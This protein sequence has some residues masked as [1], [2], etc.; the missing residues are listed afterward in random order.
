MLYILWLAQ[1]FAHPFEVGWYG[2]DMTMTLDSELVR[3]QYTQEVPVDFLLTEFKDFMAMAEGS[4]RQKAERF[5]A[6]LYDDLAA[7]L[8]LEIDGKP[9]AWM[10]AQPTH[11]TLRRQDQFF[12]LPLSLQAKLPQGVHQLLL[13]NQNRMENKGIY[14]SDIQS[15]DAIVV[16]KSN[17]LEVEA[18][19]IRKNHNLSWKKEEEFREVRLVYSSRHAA[20]AM[21]WRWWRKW[22]WGESNDTLRPEPSFAMQQQPPSL[23][24]PTPLMGLG[25]LVFSFMVGMRWALHFSKQ[26]PTLLY[27]GLY[28]GGLWC[29]QLYPPVIHW[30]LTVLMVPG[31]FV[32]R[33]SGWQMHKGLAITGVVVFLY[34]PLALAFAVL[35]SWLVGSVIRICWREKN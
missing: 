16:Q 11:R 25:L 24:R 7:D 2:H 23:D 14:R 1:A 13:I 8:R 18:G 32:M 12:L 6:S 28:A 10:K 34:M 5:V 9:Q 4:E 35:M 17:L 29:L 3:I 15:S 20:S 27:V 30:A 22:V 19:E 33:G 21:M 26:W 31:I